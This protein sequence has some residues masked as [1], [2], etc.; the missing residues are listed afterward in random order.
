MFLFL[1]FEKISKL[2]SNVEVLDTLRKITNDFLLFQN[3]LFKF[4]QKK[5]EITGRSENQRCEYGLP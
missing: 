4:C 5:V 2:D 3:Q 1:C